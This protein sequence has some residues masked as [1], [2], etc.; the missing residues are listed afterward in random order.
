M[1]EMALFSINDE[2]CL[3]RRIFV[4]DVV[5][6][7]YFLFVRYGNFK[8]AKEPILKALALKP[9]IIAESRHI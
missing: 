1:W 6:N 8:V 3:R 4:D 7:K 9:K 2:Y 5:N